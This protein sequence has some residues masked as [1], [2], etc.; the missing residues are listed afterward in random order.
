MERISF[1]FSGTPVR[2]PLPRIKGRPIVSP[3]NTS[4]GFG[5]TSTN[6]SLTR[7]TRAFGS[8]ADRIRRIVSRS[9]VMSNAKKKP[10]AETL[11]RCT[12]DHG[13]ALVIPILVQVAAKTLRQRERVDDNVTFCRGVRYPGHDLATS[14]VRNGIG[15]LEKRPFPVG[16]SERD[17]MPILSER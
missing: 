5:R 15:A 3:A 10:S 17:Q 9:V 14:Q 7:Y 6:P 16:T 1:S 13:F 12:T 4:T 8:H 11:P 2:N